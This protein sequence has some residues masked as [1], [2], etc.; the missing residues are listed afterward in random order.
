MTRRGRVLAA[1]S[2]KEP[3]RTPVDLG[4]MRSTGI[5]AIAYHR[6]KA[7]LG[8]TS[9][10]THVYDVVQQLAQPEPEI[11]EFA[12]ADV[13]DLGRTFLTEPEDW[14]DFTLQGGLPAKVP[15]YVNLVSSEGG[16]LAKHKDGTVIGVMPK[17]AFY[18]SQKYFPLADWDG[19]DRAVLD[20]L[21]EL[22][23]KVTWSALPSAPFHEPS[24]PGHLAEVRRRA[25][26]LFETTDYAVMVGFG[27]NLLEWGEYLCGMDR[28]LTDLAEDRPKVEALLDK[29]VEM[30]LASLEKV[31]DAIEGY[32]QVIQMGD[33]LG[34]QLA[35][36]ISPRMYREI[37]KPRH[38]LIYE[39]V[40]RR[41]GIHLFLHSCG[42]IADIIPDLIEI[43]VEILNPVQTSGRGMEPGRLKR[44]F[45]KDLV[46][47]GGGCDTR[48]VLPDGTPDEVHRHVR[49][50]IKILGAGGGFVFCQVHN[51]LPNVP[52]AN[53][54]AMYEAVRESGG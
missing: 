10:A 41:K 23:E 48:D 7:H 54:A 53:I 29:L 27:G 38:R 44:E 20:R 16:W 3:D 31:L 33:D 14:K 9:G 52:P 13:V 12:G 19:R 2:H 45:G 35:T 50:R 49:E 34:T 37:F 18:L 21:P 22:M 30:H 17:D 11:L 46:F 42:A 32:V 8:M 1:I 40:R 47:W 24:T 51:I 4:A 28:F 39:R 25:K 26:T 43:G 6:L 5:T 15:R 36:V